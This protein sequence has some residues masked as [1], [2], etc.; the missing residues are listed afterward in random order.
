MRR[1]WPAQVLA[2]AA[3]AAPLALAGPA[4]AQDS[5]KPSPAE[6]CAEAMASYGA[7]LTGDTSMRRAAGGRETVYADGKLANGT[8]VRMR[9]GISG[10]GS[11]ART[12]IYL[13]AAA[14]SANPSA[15]WTDAAEYL[16]PPKEVAKTDPDAAQP[17]AGTETTPPPE[18]EAPKPEG[19][20][21]KPEGEA[22]KPEGEA[23]QAEGEAP[24]AE[25]EAPP[26]DDQRSKFKR[27]PTPSG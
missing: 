21:P 23:P 25:G 10:A 4:Q 13:P 6:I 18:G 1:G 24:K 12:E 26:V 19:E 2:A 3:L 7:T 5:E 22:A 11:L 27:A 20:A 8:K 14:G 16:G 9:C 15:V 17:P